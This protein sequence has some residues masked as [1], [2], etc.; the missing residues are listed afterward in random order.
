M[1]HD[2]LAVLGI[3]IVLGIRT[4]HAYLMH[5]MFGW[6][7]P[8]GVQQAYMLHGCHAGTLDLCRALACNAA[9]ERRGSAPTFVARLPSQRSERTKVTTSPACNRPL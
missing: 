4:A 5:L 3:R 8:Q 6:Q 2:L 7:Q 1:P 9:C